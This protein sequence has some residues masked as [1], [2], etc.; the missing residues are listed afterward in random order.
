MNS[1]IAAY[2][3]K[4]NQVYREHFETHQAQLQIFTEGLSFLTEN[5]PRLFE[6][7][8]EDEFRV[9]FKAI[10]LYSILLEECGRPKVGR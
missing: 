10:L 9:R 8:E 7:H 4:S 5:I 3:M 6:P 2:G 1:Y